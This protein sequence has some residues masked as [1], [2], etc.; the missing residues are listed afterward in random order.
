MSNEDQILEAVFNALDDPAKSQP[1]VD[2]LTMADL[3]KLLA[4]RRREVESIADPAAERGGPASK[5]QSA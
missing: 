1:I 5:G 4:A 2:T 3:Q